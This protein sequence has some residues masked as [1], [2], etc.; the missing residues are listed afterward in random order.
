MGVRKTSTQELECRRV[1]GHEGWWVVDVAVPAT[2]CG[3]FGRK[4]V[5]GC[6]LARGAEI[7]VGQ[8]ERERER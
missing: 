7:D 4:G 1:R 6:V 8:R 3:A 5:A 2:V